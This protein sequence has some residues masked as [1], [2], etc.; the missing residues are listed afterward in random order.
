MAVQRLITAEELAALDD[1]G[2]RYELIDGELIRMPPAKPVHGWHVGRVIG[3][4]FYFNIAHRLGEVF[5]SSIGYRFGIAPD[6]VIQP[7]G[8]FIRHDRLPPRDAWEEYFTIAPDLAFE[9]RSP[10]ER[11]ALVDRK[12]R[13]YL[14]AGTRLL[15][16]FDPGPRRATVY[17]PGRQPLVL[18]DAETL[19]G[20]DVLPGFRLP[21]GDIFG[22]ANGAHRSNGAGSIG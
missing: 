8:S 22:T 5:D 6:T 18:T 17:A 21:L 12:V 20:E 19:D 7:D 3:F 15:W 11:R 14:A 16:Y 10:S 4:L 1:D 2:Y 9:V 13:I